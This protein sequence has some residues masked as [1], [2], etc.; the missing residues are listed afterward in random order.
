MAVIS[1]G[2]TVRTVIVESI[3]RRPLPEGD[4]SQGIGEAD[5][6]RE[7]LDAAL[8]RLDRLE[9]EQDFYRELLD[10]PRTR[11]KLSAP[12]AEEDVSDAESV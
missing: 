11:G 12:Q 9:E 1:V 2:R 4:S 6:M 3:R 8:A 10:S 5:D 7:A